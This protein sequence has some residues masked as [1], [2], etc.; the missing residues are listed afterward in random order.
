M[1]TPEDHQRITDAVAEAEAG[2]RGDIFCV[3]AG[4]VSSYRETPLAWGAAIA[5]TVP[6]LVLAFAFRPVIDAISGGG[7]TVG[8]AA[9]IEPQLALILSAYAIAQILLFGIVTMLVSIPDVRRLLTPAFLKRH[10]VKKAAFHH[11]AA[12]KAHTR[13]SDTGIV[14]FIALVDRQVEILAD[15]AIHEKV[16]DQVWRDAAAAI[17][18]GMKTPDPTSGIVGAIGLCGAALKANFPADG[19]R[20]V[21][22]KPVDD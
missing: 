17:A 10:R 21:A 13:D 19:P 2:T 8:H 6:P 12:A 9:A 16:G 14:L 7:W 15:K 22:D 18:E 11:F 20:A 3:L 5:L 1:L 4:E